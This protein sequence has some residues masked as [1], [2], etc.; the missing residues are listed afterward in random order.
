[1]FVPPANV[2][3]ALVELEAEVRLLKPDSMRGGLKVFMPFTTDGTKLINV[4]PIQ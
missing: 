3:F 4:L 1:L 2:P